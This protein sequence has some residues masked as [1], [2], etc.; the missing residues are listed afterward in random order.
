MS[1]VFSKIVHYAKERARDTVIADYVVGTGMSAVLLEDGRCGVSHLFR[2]ELPEGCSIFKSLIE[3]PVS[4]RRFFENTDP[5]HPVTASLIL[6]A[7]NAVINS[8]H[9][10]DDYTQE[11]PFV[12]LH[13]TEQDILGFVGDFR[14]LTSLINEQVGEV[15]IFERHLG[16]N[17]LPDWSIPFKLP[18]CTCVV[19]TATSIMNRTIDSVL[20]SCFTDRVVVMGPSTPM[21]LELFPQKVRSLGGARIIDSKKALQIA[22]RAGGTKNLYSSEAAQK[23]TLTRK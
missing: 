19:I 14:P 16:D 3:T 5:F 7:C 23:I 20:E 17:Y 9:D 10:R 4:L 8:T 6:A 11:D 21:S 22:S 12:S 1:D 13:I 15:R 18:E 2:E